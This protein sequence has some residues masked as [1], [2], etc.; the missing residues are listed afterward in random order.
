MLAKNRYADPSI[1]Q[2]SRKCVCWGREGSCSSPVFGFYLYC[3]QHKETKKK[4]KHS[5]ST[6]YRNLGTMF[7][8]YPT[9]WQNS[10]ICHNQNHDYILNLRA[11]FRSSDSPWARARQFA[12]ARKKSQPSINTGTSNSYNFRGRWGSELRTTE[13]SWTSCSG[14]RGL[15]ETRKGRKETFPYLPKLFFVL[16]LLFTFLFLC[17]LLFLAYF[18]ISFMTH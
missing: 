14:R 7:Y 17:W 11:L 6:F 9:Y 2:T 15:W 1:T 8:M 18:S 10:Q 4:K 5:L 13:D 16:P 3:L 12:E